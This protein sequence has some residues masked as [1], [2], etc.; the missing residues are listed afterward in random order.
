VI[1]AEEGCGSELLS[2]WAAT[3]SL[4]SNVVAAEH[5]TVA[6]PAVDLSHVLAESSS[7]LR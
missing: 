7:Q 6:A 3:H 2:C 4:C 5:S 1:V